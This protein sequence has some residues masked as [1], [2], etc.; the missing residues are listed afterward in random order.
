MTVLGSVVS[1]VVPKGLVQEGAFALTV[2]LEEMV[3]CQED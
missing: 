1:N 2:V 3:L